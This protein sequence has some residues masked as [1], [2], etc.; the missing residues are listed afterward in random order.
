MPSSS[1][2][3]QAGQFGPNEWLVEEMYQRFLD[4]PAAVD[5]AWHDFFADYRPEDGDDALTGNGTA[6]TAAAPPKAAPEESVAEK[7]VMQKVAPGKVT[8]GPDPQVNGAAPIAAPALPASEKPAAGSAS[9]AARP[10][11]AVEEGTTTPLRGA[12]S[13]V[14]KNMEASLEVPTA[15]NSSAAAFTGAAAVPAVP[16]R[17]G[18]ASPSSG[19]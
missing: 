9:K 7:S 18:A 2:S 16:L 4:D 19:R 15:T 12:A 13:M 11:A 3:S 6:G 10:A 5:P 14:V 8:H 1:M 17:V